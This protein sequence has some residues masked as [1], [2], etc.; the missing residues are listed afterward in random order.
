MKLPRDF[1]G[2]GR[3]P[4]KFEWPNG[5]RLAVNI[6][7]NY[8]EGAERSPLDGDPER[9]AASESVFPVP[10]G[11]R[12]IHQESVYEYGSRV[13]IYRIID[14]FDKYQ[15]KP[16]LYACA[17]ALERNPPVTR[18]FVDRQY[19]VVSHGYRWITHLGFSEAQER[20]Q[21]RKA[22]DSFQRTIGRRVSGW[23]N[24]T[25]Q[26]IH[27]RRILA[28]EGFLYDSGTVNDDIPFYED[29]A[30]RPFLIVPYTIDINDVRFWR[31]T[32]STGR[33]FETYCVD[34]FD[35]LYRESACTPRMMSIGL[36][37]KIIGRPGRIGGLDRFLAYVRGYPDVWLAGR[38]DI[39]RFWAER[40]APA[41]AWNWPQ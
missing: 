26:T 23:F 36:H 32:M 33:D 13:G 18:E 25:P 4:P 14:L 15:V 19:D 30:G 12:E 24:R 20:D 37:P 38:T 27:T 3:N 7:V 22:Q 1:I 29:V 9:E 40:F 35:T 16:T 8:E 10:P 2:Y 6:V 17:L 41:N 31:G 11:E 21:I 39:A 34:S 5:A 28:E